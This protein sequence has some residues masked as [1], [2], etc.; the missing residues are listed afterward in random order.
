MKMYPYS[1]TKSCEKGSMKVSV[2]KTK[3]SRRS[4]K[5]A[6]DKNPPK[7][8]QGRHYLRSREHEYVLPSLGGL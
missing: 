7:S 2:L 6:R 4:N 1:S 3:Q 8:E 5:C